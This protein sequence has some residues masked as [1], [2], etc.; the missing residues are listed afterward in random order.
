MLIAALACYYLLKGYE[1]SEVE[2]TGNGSDR[3]EAKQREFSVAP[4]GMQ[5]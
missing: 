4:K 1:F 5:I 2:Q 3:K